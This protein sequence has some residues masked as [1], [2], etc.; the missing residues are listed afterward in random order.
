MSN[1]SL[2]H[3]PATGGLTFSTP[4]A[5]IELPALWLRERSPDPTQLEAMT[6]QR[7]FDSHGIDPLIAVSSLEPVG[8]SQAW[9]T[10]SD[11]HRALYDFEV[12]SQEILGHSRF[13]TVQAWDSSLDMA[14]VRVDWQQMEQPQAF[15]AALEAYLTYGFIVLYNVPCERESVLEVGR[16]FGYI[17]ETN[18]GRY[19]EVYSRPDGN[20]LAYRSVFLGPHT[21]NPYRDPVPGIQLLHCLINQTSGGLSTLVDSVSV[22]KQLADEDP[23]GYRQLCDI[24]VQY[25]FIDKG[26]ELLTQRPVINTDAHGHTLGV[27]YSPRLDGLPLLPAAALRHYHKAR[28]RLGQLFSD[29]A[30]E[31]RFRLDAGELM[32]FDNSRVLHGR[33]AYD[34]SEGHRHLQGC[35]I[36]LDGPRER[37]ASTLKALATTEAL[38]CTP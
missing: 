3:D 7:L 15:R 10:F 22:V 29:P 18:F 17:K 13:P 6:Q 21:D 31:L 11:A 37:F 23:Q 32:L 1:Y 26:T 36:D 35:Y 5:A 16:K 24:A 20:D 28:Q 27:H 33:T 2:A 14:K 30:Y 9:L 19:F 12:L 25:R 38:P 34:P 8:K 4:G